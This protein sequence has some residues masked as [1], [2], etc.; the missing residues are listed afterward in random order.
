VAR[1]E[2]FRKTTSDTQPGAY[3]GGDLTFYGL[4]GDARWERCGLP[5]VGEAGLA[6]AFRAEVLHEVRPVAWGERYSL[7]AW[8]SAAGLDAAGGGRHGFV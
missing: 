4:L 8:Y 1:A 2:S 5:L 6:A 3:G 7:V